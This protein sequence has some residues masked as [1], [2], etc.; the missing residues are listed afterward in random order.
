MIRVDLNC[1]MGESTPL[2]S[3]LIEKDLSILPYISSVNL[4]CGF[5]AGDPSTMH[6]L[7]EAA[8]EREIAVGAHPAFPDKDNFGRT[9]L[10]LPPEQVYDLVVYQIGAL[11]AFLQIYNA[12]LHHVK[13]HGALYNMAAKDRSLADA[14]CQAVKDF[15]PHLMI[16]GLAGSELI[17][18]ARE[19]GLPAAEEA[20]A[21][22]TY[23]PDGSLTPRTQPHALIEDPEESL[24][25][26]LQMLQTGSVAVGGEKTIPIKADTICIHGDGKHAVEFART[27][28]QSLKQHHVS[29]QQP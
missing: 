2:H 10:R 11:Q 19:R 15:D 27:I 13:A 5:H 1:D 3:Y 22:R 29:I 24:Q 17:H 12:R 21:D 14:I 26:V 25:Q 9:N 7:V 8:L 20:F 28:Y 16:Y 6:Q 4:A 18:A 23:Q